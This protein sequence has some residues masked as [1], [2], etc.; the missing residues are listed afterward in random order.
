MIIGVKSLKLVMVISSKFNYL[1][2]FLSII[3]FHSLIKSIY[4][5]CLIPKLKN[6]EKMY[7]KNLILLLSSRIDT[8]QDSN[9]NSF[10]LKQLIDSSIGILYLH[11]LH[12]KH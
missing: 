1:L 8:L 12:Y 7:L 2:F 6:H 9:M 3:D 5:G 11:S 10:S 4:Q